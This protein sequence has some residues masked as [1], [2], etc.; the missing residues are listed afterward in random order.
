[1]LSD[2]VLYLLQKGAHLEPKRI[3]TN[4]I[5]EDIGISQQTASR[6][7]LLLE[8]E[9]NISRSEGGKIQLSPSAVSSARK[10][11]RVLLDS[12]DGASLT[13]SGKVTAGL[14]Q[15]AFFLS[16]KEYSSAFEKM[17][18]IRPFKGTLNV[19][20]DAGDIEKRISLREKAPI[21]VPGFTKGKR[22]FG[23]I[24]CYRCVVSGIPCA[25]VFPEMSIHGLQVLEIIS[26]F[27]L[28]KKLSLSDNSPLQ[29][30]IV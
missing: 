2:I 16:Q 28:R 19:L 15:G 1:M 14:G 25:I 5:A 11:L 4:Q 13:F 27:N 9:G 30:E 24:D 10:Y 12:L 20:I 7:L 17:L 29:I 21:T 6:K 26:S 8:K 18:G 23:K 22:K 3:T